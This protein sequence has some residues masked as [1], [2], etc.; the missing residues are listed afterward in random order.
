MQ[1]Q[2][3]VGSPSTQVTHTPVQLMYP[4]KVVEKVVEKRLLFKSLRKFPRGVGGSGV[5]FWSGSVIARIAGIFFRSNG[6]FGECPW[7][8]RFFWGGV[9]RLGWVGGDLLGGWGGG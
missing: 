3:Q 6:V 2:M 9:A 8:A 4:D 1:P 5:F 7:M